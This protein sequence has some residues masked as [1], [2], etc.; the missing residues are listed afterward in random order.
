M[1]YINI[2][3]ILGI[4]LNT[5]CTNFDTQKSPLVIRADSFYGALVAD[6]IIYDVIIKNPNPEDACTNECL[7]N[8]QHSTLMDSLFNL[9]Y[10]RQATVYDFFSQEPLKVKEIK[11]MEK[12]E[13]FM[14]DNIGKIQFTEKWYF[15]A[16]T[17]QLQKEVIS[18]VLGYELKSDEGEVRGYKPIFKIQLNH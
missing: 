7:K 3:F 8:F 14:R 1:K 18:M 15:D 6:T 10:T 12:E 17:Q 2:F 4:L 11:R 16:S 9:V 13:D 5:A